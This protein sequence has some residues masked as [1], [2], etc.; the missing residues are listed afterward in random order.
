MTVGV[1]TFCYGMYVS[2]RTCI[3]LCR[4]LC[5]QGLFKLHPSFD[6]TIFEILAR[7]KAA[8][9]IF[10]HDDK[11]PTWSHLLRKRLMTAAQTL[12]RHDAQV[13]IFVA[14]IAF[15]VTVEIGVTGKHWCRL[16]VLPCWMKNG[17]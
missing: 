13:H 17:V 14:L 12:T 9:I 1:L 2:L 16:G 7:D 10:M 15:I 6:Q 8:V 11:K 3:V 4:Y 5:F